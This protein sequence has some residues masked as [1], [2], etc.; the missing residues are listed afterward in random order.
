MELKFN[1]SDKQVFETAVNKFKRGLVLHK[2]NPKCQKFGER[3]FSLDLI[4][5]QLVSSTTEFGKTEKRCK[6]F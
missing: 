6:D 4:N 5:Y 2:L 1:D 3:F